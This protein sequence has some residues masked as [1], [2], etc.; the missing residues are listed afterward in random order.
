MSNTQYSNN[1][2]GPPFHLHNINSIDMNTQN[3]AFLPSGFETNRDFAA[4]QGF[5][6][7]GFAFN[8][9][10]EMDLSG[11]DRGVDQPSPAT[12]STQ[13]RG[14]STSQSSYSP[15]QP[16]EHTLPYRASPKMSGPALGSGTGF[17]GFVATSETYSAN[18]FGA[19]GNMGEERYND[20]FVMG[21]EWEYAAL[22]GGT[23]FTPMVDASWDS[24]LESVTMG[25]ESLG[26]EGNR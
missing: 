4:T 16:I 15:G 19:P 7:A 3:T 1:T 24:M 17:P 14:G 23:G 5:A 9:G 6:P 2:P 20:A 8:D 25:W 11:G 21:N 12:I 22:N 18:N 26:P 10:T 13:S